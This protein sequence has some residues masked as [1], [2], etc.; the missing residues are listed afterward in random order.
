MMAQLSEERFGKSDLKK[1]I[2]VIVCLLSYDHLP[3]PYHAEGL[4]DP[5]VLAKKPRNRF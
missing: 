1:S 2:F 3:C 4:V 5:K